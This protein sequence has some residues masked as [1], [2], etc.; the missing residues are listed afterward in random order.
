[1]LL[2]ENLI[3]VNFSLDISNNSPSGCRKPAVLRAVRV[4]CEHLRTENKMVN[5]TVESFGRGLLS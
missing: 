1:M 5:K 3:L 2:N 4:I